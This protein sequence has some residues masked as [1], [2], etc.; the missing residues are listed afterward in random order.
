MIIDF[1][2][3][4]F[5][6][7]IAEKAIKTLEENLLLTSGNPD[8]AFLNGTLGD[9]ISSMNKNDISYSVVMPIATSTKQAESI[10]RF[11]T[12]ITGKNNIISF[13]SVHP[14]QGDC[15]EYLKKIKES[16]LLGIKLHPEYQ[17]FYIDS[18]E[19][20]KILTEAQNLGLLVMLHT[21]EDR[22]IKPPVHC[23]PKMLKNA[24]NYICGENII[25][26]H[27]G[28]YNMW[29]EVYDNL[30]KTPIY[31]DTSYSVGIMDD[32]LAKAIIKKHG[33]DKILFGTDSP[34][35]DQGDA[36]KALKNLNLDAETE[37]KIFYKNAQN[38]LGL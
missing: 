28:G 22:G 31:L 27:M 36:V 32:E 11:A 19:S 38:L 34:W 30:C 6:D 14:L 33:D 7:K 10:N 26:A 4:I 17:G 13:G 25:A 1:H 20:I 24:L 35:Q 8:K 2:T 3:H 12:E 5:P 21:G 16:G 9:L 15:L 18:P 37:D 23:T 29:E